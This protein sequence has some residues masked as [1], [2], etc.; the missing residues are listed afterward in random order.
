MNPRLIDTFH[1]T[2]PGVISI[3][4][5]GGKTSLMFQLAKQIADSGNTVLTTTT[6]R[7]FMPLPSQSPFTIIDSSIG[8]LVKKSK[9]RLT[10]FSHF[11]AGKAYDLTTGKLHGFA[12]DRIDQLWQAGLF[13]WIIVEADGARQKPLKATAS[14][15]PV[16]P[17][18]TTHLIL[19]AGLDAVG[20]PLNETHVHRAA[21]FS[22][23][24]GLPLGE[25]VN[26]RSM[27]TCI[28]F[29]V[30][31]AGNLCLALSTIVCLNKAD[32]PDK[33]RSGK[34]IAEFLKTNT[35]IHR[36][37]MTS[38]VNEFPVRNCLILER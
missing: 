25:I 24:T 8:R 14:H 4:G 16:I 17:G 27:A 38:L 9:A 7:L 10:C 26:E 30:E 19:T 13:D 18:V 34:K 15:E 36:I 2:G 5:A 29:E 11:S 22:Q 31:K 33:I 37:I 6:T 12:P 1:L 32:S 3:I 21:L 28:A 23:N 35:L 20:K